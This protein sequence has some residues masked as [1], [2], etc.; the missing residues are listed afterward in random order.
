MRETRHFRGAVSALL[1]SAVANLL[2]PQDAHAD[3]YVEPR[4]EHFEI[5]AQSFAG[6]L[7]AYARQT[8]EQVVFFSNLGTGCTVPRI[9]GTFTRAQ[10]LEQ[11]LANTGL[12]Y[13][14]VNANTIAV[15]PIGSPISKESQ[16]RPTPQSDKETAMS[17]RY[18][19]LCCSAT[20][21]AMLSIGSRATADDAQGVPQSA[22]QAALQEV[23]VTGIRSSLKHSL[24]AKRNADAIVDGISA[25]DIGKFPDKN[26]A[27][28]LQRI[29]G[30]SVDRVWGE[31]RDVFVRG[32]DS[33]LNRTQ[34]NGQNVAS[35]YWWANDNPSRGFNY[36]I[37]A[38]ELVSSLEVYKSPEADMDEGSIGGLVSVR[39]RRPMELK[40]YTLQVSGEALHSVL[41]DKTDPQASGLFSWHDD[42]R[43]FGALASLSYQRREMR[44][45]ALEGFNDE[46]LYNITD[47]NGKV[48]PNVHA[49]YG[50]GS[51]LFVEDRRRL[52]ENATLQWRPLQ[53]WDLTLNYVNSDMSADNHNENYLYLI[54][55][56]LQAGAIVTDPV[57]IP[58]GD[59][60][61]ALV[62]GTIGNSSGYG[63]AIEAI[64]RK[65]FVKS[66]VA[67]LDTTY[68]L[69]HWSIHG[70]AGKTGAQGGSEHD[71]NYYFEASTPEKI[72]LGPQHI[73]VSYLDLDPTNANALHFA[74][75]NERDWPRTITEN[76]TYAQSD[77]TFDLGNGFFKSF[78]TGVKYRDDTVENTR[79]IGSVSTSNPNY[80]AL[81]AITLNQVTSG[82]SP[83]L[84]QQ[85]A[86]QGSVTRYALVDGARAAALI[87]PMLNLQYVLDPLAFYIIEEHITAAYAKA[88]FELGAL[89]GNFG[90][91]AVH[92]KQQSTAYDSNGDLET[93]TRPYSNVLPSINAVYKVS[94]NLL[95]RGA[96]SQAMARDTFQNLSSNITINATTG[97]A[98]A[99]NPYLTP[100]KANQFEIGS[101]WYF[102]EASLLSGT[103]FWKSLNTFVYTQSDEEVIN[104]QSLVVTRP[105]N[106][107]HG[108][109]IQ[110][111]EMQWQQAIWGGFGI[112]TNYTFTNGSV[113]P[114][115][116]QPK[117]QLQGNSK[118]QANASLYFE[119]PRWSA[120]VS[121][122]FRSEAFGGLTMGSQI[123]T[124]PYHQV[125]ATA[126]FN[127]TNDFTV[128]ATAVNITN[129]LLR[130][131]TADGVP[132]ELYENG[133]R[134]SLGVRLKF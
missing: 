79:E 68:N 110:G 53:A 11:I 10:V 56:P 130:Q 25:E 122:N 33:T 82:T 100:I 12:T 3:E 103:Y 36:D 63:A 120:R 58:T 28:A 126:S 99:G 96:A 86:T 51:A 1:V 88:D 89:R 124:D 31:G 50:G 75:G 32:T 8:G 83:P 43:R 6:A 17:H 92:T 16:P 67:D 72:S 93:I 112:V 64:Y 97:S 27:D 55:S 48:T 73:D 105:F 87:N 24:D 117:L 41:G 34:M 5:R 102:S 95:V 80:A 123:V 39:T 81:T 46:T 65:A 84:S 118:H 59:G 69:D 85:A 42:D 90:V 40:P 127:A 116:G 20:A 134:Y 109:K 66:H 2:I 60:K 76:E 49:L 133:S 62:G 38:S 22:P 108:A 29:P 52:T 101:E 30:V 119:S 70:Q 37:L 78:K 106:S 107:D 132:L 111:L 129:E 4:K 44:R 23:I 74:P 15:S 91:R 71:Q 21:L 77:L 26:V 131:H 104:G 57:F 113:D 19:L 13:Q 35:A 54:Q 114:I 18:P 125:D 94:D 98:T 115:P 9:S 45:D 61:Q 128:F 121:Y 14:R 7:Q 47:Q